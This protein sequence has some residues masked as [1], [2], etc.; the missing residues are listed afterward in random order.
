[1]PNQNISMD[2]FRVIKK[3]GAGAR[4]TIYLAVDLS[5]NKKVAL[6]R[7][8]FETEQDHRIFEQMATEYKM[9]NKINHPYIRKCHPLIKKRKF[10]KTNEIL[11]PM[12]L[13][14]G[15]SLE[16]SPSLSLGDILLVFRM[17]AT[18]LDAMH[19][20]GLI[21]CDIKPNN[22]LI[23]P[24]GSIKIIDLGQSCRFGTIKSRIQGTPDYIAP[25]QVKR[26]QLSHRTD[27]FNLGATMYWAMTGKNVP[28]LISQKMDIGLQ[29]NNKE[30]RAPHKIYRKIPR[31][32]SKLVM[33]CVEEKPARR[34]ENMSEVIAT[35][36]VLIRDIFSDKYEKNEPE[37][38]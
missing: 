26:Q 11:M 9:S 8:V 32:V 30:F 23:S 19:Q 20:K 35:F 12:E 27:I 28:T 5:T 15:R 22:I 16:E 21:H 6:K 18:G 29:T 17:I 14:V 13:F 24:A 1:M 3:L 34:P 38:N 7:A 4:T 25:E 2:G 10:F 31:Q 36:D 37:N 33:K